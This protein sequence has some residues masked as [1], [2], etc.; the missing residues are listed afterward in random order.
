MTIIGQFVK[1]VNFDS[2]LGELE[3]NCLRSLSVTWRGVKQVSISM[4]LRTHHRYMPCVFVF[5]HII[6]VIYI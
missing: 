3:Q 2:L 6:T 5:D 4:L 1:F